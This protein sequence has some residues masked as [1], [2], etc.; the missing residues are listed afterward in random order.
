MKDMASPSGTGS[1]SRGASTASEVS[2]RAGQAARDAQANVGDVAADL[3]ETAGRVAGQAQATAG[4]IAGHVTSVA[5]DVA[6]SQKTAGV[7]MLRQFSRAVNAA[8]DQLRNDAPVPAQY[9]QELGS[10]LDRAA[11]ELG[12]RDLGQLANTVLDFARRQPA[13]FVAGTVLTG[14]VLSRFLKSSAETAM[15]GSGT[16]AGSWQ[17]SR[18]GGSFAGVGAGRP[19][20]GPGMDAGADDWR[21]TAASRPASEGVPGSTGHLAGGSS[22]TGGASSEL[23][24]TQT[25]GS[26]VTG[27]GSTQRGGDDHVR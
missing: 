4:E 16:G 2:D 18:Q 23:G 19:G 12:R 13:T 22:G 5:S 3:K 1:P 27:P 25:A 24:S 10:G 15:R 26:S 21:R 17:G 9:V 6:E 8:A 20:G 7:D 14:F 11:D